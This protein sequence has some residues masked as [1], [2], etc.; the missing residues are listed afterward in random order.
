MQGVYMHCLGSVLLQVSVLLSLC[1][2]SCWQQGKAAA[3][4]VLGS[5]AHMPHSGGAAITQGVLLL[6]CWLLRCAAGYGRL[7]VATPSQCHVY[8]TSNWNTPTIF[9]L[10]DSL[11]LL[12]L[13][14]RCML[15]LDNVG[16]LQ[17]WTYEGRPL[18][19]PKFPGAQHSRYCAAQIWYCAAQIWYCAAQ[20]W[21]CASN[22]WLSPACES[23]NSGT[24]CNRHNLP[25]WPAAW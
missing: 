13:S 16:G 12:Q 1:I 14:E 6:T 24:L 4:L 8:S 19:S 22:P 5:W 17:I 7:V 3:A 9:D 23:H 25:A 20:I 11:R 2:G 18:C 10:K 15:T 21:Y